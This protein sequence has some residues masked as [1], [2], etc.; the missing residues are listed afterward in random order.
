MRRSILRTFFAAM[1]GVA[2]LAPISGAQDPA[3]PSDDTKHPIT[4]TG[5]VRA[6]TDRG[7][8]M[9]MNVEEVNLAKQA[10]A[11]PLDRNGR[12]V[13]YILNSS[14][15]FDEQVGRRVEVVGTVDLTDADK[16]QMKVT[17]DQTKKMDQKIEIKGDRETVTVEA[18]TKPGIAPDSAASPHTTTEPNR[19]LYRLDVKSM[20]R[21]PSHLCDSVVIFRPVS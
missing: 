15:G 8:F 14:K 13:I 12:D 7:S 6:G 10:Q 20:R 16:A 19:V 1:A 18:D 17:D 2:T 21:V 4:I 5:C 3:H 9:L 11:V